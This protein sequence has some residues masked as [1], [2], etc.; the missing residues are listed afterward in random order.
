M[1]E[2]S[3]LEELIRTRR[4]A[5]DRIERDVRRLQ[6]DL[7]NISI[8]IDAYEKALVLINPMAATQQR[9]PLEL[10]AQGTRPNPRLR[11]VSRQPR[12]LSPRW[13]EILSLAAK[14]FPNGFNYSD[15]LFVFEMQG[16]K[17]SPNSSVRSQMMAYVNS[18]IAERIS[19]GQFR[20]T[21]E[22]LKQLG[23]EPIEMKEAPAVDAEASQECGDVAELLNAS[24]YESE[25]PNTVDAGK[26]QAVQGSVGSN[27]TVS[28]TLRREL[29]SSSSSKPIIQPPVFP[30]RK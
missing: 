7:Q 1:I 4:A 8:E 27:P 11:A 12:S 19:N 26:A 6:R 9:L 30:A 20:I 24:D 3:A 2:T 15:L 22:G 5:A 23:I 25:E 28:T 17:A 29:M 18:G 10:P 16:D 13:K 21:Q 14:E